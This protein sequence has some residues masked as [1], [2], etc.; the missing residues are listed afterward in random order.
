V[1]RHFC[2]DMNFARL[3]ESFLSFEACRSAIAGSHAIRREGDA[4]GAFD[5]TG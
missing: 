1:Y 4:L 3:R 2:G 5:D